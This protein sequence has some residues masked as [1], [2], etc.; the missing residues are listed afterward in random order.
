MLEGHWADEYPS[1]IMED[2]FPHGDAGRV[3]WLLNLVLGEGL[4]LPND[5]L[6]DASRPAAEQGAQFAQAGWQ[7][8]PTPLRLKREML[9]YARRNRDFARQQEPG[10]K[11]AMTQKAYF[12]GDDGKGQDILAPVAA[13]DDEDYDAIGGDAWD[14]GAEPE[15][16]AHAAPAGV[17]QA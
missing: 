13:A 14:D 15:S 7:E 11:F 10:R 6:I 9:A 4:H 5:M 2:G 17:A 12:F 1:Q 16:A 3:T 8:P